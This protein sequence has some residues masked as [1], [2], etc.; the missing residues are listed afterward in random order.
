[1]YIGRVTF[2][3]G[4]HLRIAVVFGFIGVFFLGTG[5]QSFHEGATS[6]AVTA[7]VAG[8]VFFGGASWSATTL[9]KRFQRKR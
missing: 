6:R 8:A 5:V 4:F 3:A 2:T 1:M 9:Y 7:L